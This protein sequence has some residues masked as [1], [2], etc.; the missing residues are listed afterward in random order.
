[1]EDESFW[2]T[3]PLALDNG[4]RRGTYRAFVVPVKENVEVMTYSAVSKIILDDEG[5]NAKGNLHMLRLQRV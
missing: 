2:N 5:K 4:A 1:M 3:V